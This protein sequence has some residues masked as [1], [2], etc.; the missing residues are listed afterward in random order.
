MQGEI[1]AGGMELPQLLDKMSSHGASLARMVQ[2]EVPIS[3]VPHPLSH[4]RLWE[5]QD[6]CEEHPRL[7]VLALLPV[8]A[9]HL[10]LPDGALGEGAFLFL[11]PGHA[12]AAA[13]HHLRLPGFPRQLGLPAPLQ[14]PGKPTGKCSFCGEVKP[15]PEFG[16]KEVFS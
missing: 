1:L 12:G 13:L 7:P 9:D 8:R 4:R 5:V 2:C 14:L 15:Q 3:M 16:I 6:G 11:Q 10:Q